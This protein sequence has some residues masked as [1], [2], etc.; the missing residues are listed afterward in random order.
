[1]CLRLKGLLTQSTDG[2]AVGLVAECVCA[3]IAETQVSA[4]QDERVSH[5]RQTHHTLCTVVTD[6]IVYYLESNGKK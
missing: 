2:A 6:R 3:C 5:I 4:W 1:M